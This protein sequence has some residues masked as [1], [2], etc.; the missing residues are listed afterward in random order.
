MLVASTASTKL[1]DTQVMHCEVHV[2]RLWGLTS[3]NS[4]SSPKIGPLR[5]LVWAVFGLPA[6][7]LAVWF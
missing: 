3:C 1:L 6:A 2:V 4:P 5:G 7:A